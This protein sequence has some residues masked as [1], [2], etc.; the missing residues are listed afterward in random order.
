MDEM[1]SIRKKQEPSRKEL[2]EHKHKEKMNLHAITTKSPSQIKEII[3]RPW[4]E[5]PSILDRVSKVTHLSR[6]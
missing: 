4:M 6:K 1:I 2:P 5:I 3:E